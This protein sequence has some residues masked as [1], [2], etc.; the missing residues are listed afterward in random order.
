MFFRESEFSEASAI[1]RRC[2][3]PGSLVCR[4][5]QAVPMALGRK[6]SHLPLP[7]LPPS[8]YPLGKTFIAINCSFIPLDIKVP[9]YQGSLEKCLPKSPHSFKRNLLPLLR[10]FNFSSYHNSQLAP[11]CLPGSD[12][13]RC[14]EEP[15]IRDLKERASEGCG[16][17][18]WD[19]ART[20]TS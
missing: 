3:G 16:S 17:S 14:R 13:P 5:L 18:W 4:A 15:R 20:H 7:P 10:G 9:K 8:A 2:F 6:S 11:Y 19:R 12:C 1:G